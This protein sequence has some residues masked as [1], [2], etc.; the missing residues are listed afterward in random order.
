MILTARTN[1]GAS[2]SCSASDGNGPG[3]LFES[4]G[5]CP[6]IAAQL[7]AQINGT[8]WAFLN[9]TIALM[10]TVSGASFTVYAA[11][12][13]TVN[14]S[15]TSVSFASGQNFLGSQ[16]GDPILINGV[17]Y[18]I[19]SV[20]SPTSA[21]LTTSAGTQTGVN[22]L[23]PG[24]GRDGN[25]IELLEMHKT[26][27]AYL[28]PAGASKL[29]GGA[30]PSS[31]HFHIDF[32]ASGIDSLRQA[33]LTFAPALNYDSGS[34]N[35]ALVAYQPSTW[36][37]VF[38]NW[39]LADP[40]GVLPLKIAG[41]GSV[42]VGSRDFWASF[43]GTGWSEQ[44]GFYYRGFARQSSHS[45][46]HVTVTYSCQYTHNSVPRH[47]ALV[48]R[49][50]VD[51]H[52]R[53][54]GAADDRYL[55][56]HHVTDFRAPPHRLE[57]RARHPR[58]RPHGIQ[59]SQLAV[60]RHQLLLR[61][62]AGGGPLG[63]A[64]A[65]DDLSERQLRLRFRHRPDLRHRARARLLDS[66]QGRIRRRHRLLLRR[67]LRIETRALGR[68]FP[69]GHRH[70][71]GGVERLQS[72]VALR[73][74]RRDVPAGGWRELRRRPRNGVRR[75]GLSDRHR[76]HARAAVRQRDQHAVRRDLGGEDRDRPVHDHDAQPRGWLHP[77]HKLRRWHG[78]ERRES[79]N[80]I[81][82]RQ[83]RHQG[84]QRGRLAGGRIAIAAAQPGVHDY[85]G[86]L[87]RAGPTRLARR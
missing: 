12:Y 53:R 19:A 59:L 2:I 34:V 38:T 46:D 76:G 28:T 40:S 68:K 31:V 54:R 42:T 63:R 27:T 81:D 72:R 57:C 45:T 49:R 83:R 18:A 26:S 56:R 51:D 32:T 11:R 39:T 71:L 25:S 47:V 82:H 64:V 37:A 10:A 86:R 35:P 80:R 74:R 9:P 79:V 21:T 85:S 22:Y 61:L 24:G 60:H 1:S 3:T 87:L 66:E 8:N 69:S 84:R 5:A 65:R 41:P 7:A 4:Q 75:G 50:R 70:D 55:R 16:A 30:D 33:W 20:T 43:T 52:A 6:F 36:S 17:Q 62:F 29:T 78:R 77:V 14:T 58:G 23:A 67:L 15:G 73:R 44:T 48:R 13:G